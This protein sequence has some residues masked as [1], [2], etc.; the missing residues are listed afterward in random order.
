MLSVQPWP[1]GIRRS[2][3]RDHAQSGQELGAV[4]GRRPALRLSALGAGRA[5]QRRHG[6]TRSRPRPGRT[7]T[8]ASPARAAGP[9]AR[10]L[11]GDQSTSPCGRGTAADLP[12]TGELRCV[13]RSSAVW[14]G[15]CMGTGHHREAPP[16]CR[17]FSRDSTGTRA[18]TGQHGAGAAPPAGA[19]L[20][21]AGQ[22]GGRHLRRRPDRTRAGQRIW[23][24]GARRRARPVAPDQAGVHRGLG[25]RRR[26]GAGCPDFG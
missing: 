18:R 6:W 19:A 14:H 21:N 1:A 5:G 3:V 24:P 23:P 8:T 7:R 22:P 9:E 12:G 15:E 20:Q 10:G 16:T 13:L 4:R 2:A 25:R 11:P 17:T 26:R